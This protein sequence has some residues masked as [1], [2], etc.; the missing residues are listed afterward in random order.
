MPFKDISYLELWRP[1]VQQ[2]GIICA[3]LVEAIKRN[4]NYF[5]FGPVVQ[6]DMSFK[7][8]LIWSSGGPPVQWSRTI[9]A[10]LKEGIMANIH[11]KLYEIWTSGLGDVI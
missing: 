9:Y 1:F 7:R 2:S 10:I 3:I 4:K 6:E 11:V 5:K 8:F